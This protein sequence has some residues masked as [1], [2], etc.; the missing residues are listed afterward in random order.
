MVSSP[1]WMYTA[2]QNKIPTQNGQIWASFNSP[3]TVAF[4]K[5]LEKKLRVCVCVLCLYYQY[6]WWIK[7]YIY[8]IVILIFTSNLLLHY[9]GKSECST[10]QFYTSYWMQKLTNRLF[11]LYIV[12]DYTSV[13]FNLQHCNVFTIYAIS[14]YACFASFT[15][16]CQRMRQ[17]PVVAMLCQARSRCCRN[18]LCWHCVKWS[19]CHSEKTIKL[20]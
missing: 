6:I 8:I 19:R 10:V 14:T 12:L 3:F 2:S 15:P 5:E 16:L 11:A 17:W 13:P 1:I 20:K 7:M 18:L 9:L 4:Y